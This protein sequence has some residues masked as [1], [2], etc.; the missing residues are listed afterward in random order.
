MRRV[1]CSTTARSFCRSC[2]SWKRR[3]GPKHTLSGQRRDPTQP[4]GW[5]RCKEAATHPLTAKKKSCR[6]GERALEIQK[7]TLPVSCILAGGG[8]IQ[9]QV[10]SSPWDARHTQAT[11][12]VIGNQKTENQECEGAFTEPGSGGHSQK[13]K[14]HVQRHC[15]SRKPLNSKLSKDVL[16]TYYVPGSILGVGETAVN[17][18]DRFSALMELMTRV[19]GRGAVN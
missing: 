3:G 8:Q 12:R 17:Q 9:S 1:I 13:R 18:T 11:Q 15:G 4:Q 14:Q 10:K 16:R 5:G 7:E 19:W 2:S 6:P